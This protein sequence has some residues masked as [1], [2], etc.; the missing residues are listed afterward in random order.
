MTC[1]DYLQAK[2]FAGDATSAS[3]EAAR[4]VSMEISRQTREVIAINEVLARDN[5]RV[6]EASSNQ[7]T[8]ALNEGFDRLSYVMED[9]SE[10]INNLD[11]TFHWGFGKVI[12][13]LGHMSDT[14]EELVKIA[15]TPVQTVVF[16][17]FYIADVGDVKN[18][19]L[20]FV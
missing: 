5:V 4:S 7:I 15:K 8:G 1:P 2:S 6:M 3:R 12:A 9:I 17:H 14:L 16:N 11:A 19:Y 10:G 13:S 18:Q 20:C